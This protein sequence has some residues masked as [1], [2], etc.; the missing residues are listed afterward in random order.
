MGEKD[1]ERNLWHGKAQDGLFK[2]AAVRAT[3]EE[4]G[5]NFR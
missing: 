3:T 2:I 1:K 5:W 4:A